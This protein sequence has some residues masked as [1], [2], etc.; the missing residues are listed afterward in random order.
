MVSDEKKQL[1]R[2]AGTCS[3]IVDALSK[4]VHA[5]PVL[6]LIVDTLTELFRCQTCAIVLSEKME[7]VFRIRNNS[8]LSHLFTK[9]F[10]RQ[11]KTG[12]IVRLLFTGEPIV[13]ENREENLLE[14]ADIQLERPF[15]S[16]ACFRIMADHQ[17][18]GYLHIDFAERFRFNPA[19]LSVFQIFANL[20]AIAV[21]KEKLT[22][23]NVRLDPIDVE[24]GL[25]KFSAFVKTL[26]DH[27]RLGK[28]FNQH[29]AVLMM[30]VDSFRQ[31]V[32]V[33][34]SE[35]ADGLIVDIG[36]FVR[37]KL[38]AVDVVSRWGLDE[39][40][41]LLPNVGYREARGHAEGLRSEVEKHLFTKE[42]IH[43]TVSIGLAYFPL[44][45]EN[46]DRLLSSASVA[47]FEAQRAGRNVVVTIGGRRG[48]VRT[49][50]VEFVTGG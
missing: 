29:F 35:I 7:D 21:Q 11:Y 18:L 37:S 1:V 2:C 33:Y 50:G 14:S 22:E 13:I 32:N 6:Q 47:L 39:F 41:V 34:G 17:P 26:G 28:E 5:E 16:A 38:R 42:R 23:A 36:Q 31:I 27:I 4:I 46:V 43:C 9:A 3:T 49:Q 30:D 25:P 45:G 40:A 44:H 10:R 12:A 19:D 24:T 20:A 48:A 15:V 8:G